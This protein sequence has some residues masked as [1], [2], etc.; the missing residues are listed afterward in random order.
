MACELQQLRTENI[1]INAQI[2]RVSQKYEQ[3]AFT[4]ENVLYYTGL[5]TFQILKSLFSFSF[6]LT[7]K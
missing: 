5:P 7:I 1:D 4:G 3:E 2:Q 6:S